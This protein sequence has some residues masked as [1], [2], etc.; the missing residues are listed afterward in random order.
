MTSAFER[1]G[2]PIRIAVVGGGP[3]S[4]IG[5]VHRSAARLD[6]R[7]EI[8]AGVVSS[9]PAKARAAA[10][11][12]GI[13]RSYGTVEE[14]LAA[15][16]ARPDALEAVAVMTPN[17]RHHAVAS[18]ALAHGL[19]VICDKPMTTTLDDARDLAARV[20]QAGTVFCLTHNYSGYPMVRQARA[21]VAAGAIGAL[22]AIQVEYL[23]AGM[24]ARVESGP[25]TPKLRWKLDAERA[26]P[27]LV[28]GDI[29]THAHQLA[30]YVSGLP[31]TSLAADLG[32][33]VPG[34]AVDDYAAMLLRFGESVRGQLFASQALAGT[35]NDL[36]LR[37]FGE[38]GLIEWRQNEPNRLRHAP[39]GTAARLLARGD[40]DL[41][42]EAARLTRIPRGHPEG[43]R[44]AF[45]NLYRDAAEAIAARRLGRAPDPLAEF[46]GVADGARGV[47][48]IDAA[49]RSRAANGAWVQL[50]AI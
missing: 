24:A 17:D 34:R 14:M 23:Q 32:A 3:G 1:F 15:E 43:F 47:A 45:A 5:E 13:P 6:G 48:F 18:A 28:L 19:D 7:Y 38:S 27:S 44:E 49:I 42:P 22:R 16:T 21:M 39:L 37:V 29:G 33:L 26:G 46:P 36:N 35:E 25:L 50:T 41:L 8:V 31:L 9:D 10:A 40:P 30:C 11:A 12:F 4:F 2:R 20:Q